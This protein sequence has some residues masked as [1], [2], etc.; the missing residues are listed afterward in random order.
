MRMGM[1]EDGTSNIERQILGF[2]QD[3]GRTVWR[4]M[5]QLLPR[6]ACGIMDSHECSVNEFALAKCFAVGKFGRSGLDV[7]TR[8]VFQRADF[9]HVRDERAADVRDP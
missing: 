5:R 9:L 2:R 1:G 8:A 7:G 4:K 6:G 3:A